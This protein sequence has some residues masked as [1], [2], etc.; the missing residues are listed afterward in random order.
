MIGNQW[1][2][3]LESWHLTILGKENKNFKVLAFSIYIFSNLTTFL[4]IL[5][6]HTLEKIQ[7]FY[8]ECACFLFERFEKF[9]TFYALAFKKSPL[10]STLLR[11]SH[12]VQ[13]KKKQF[14]LIIWKTIFLYFRERVKELHRRCVWITMLYFKKIYKLMRMLVCARSCINKC[15]LLKK[16]LQ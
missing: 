7:N 11:K 16:E 13:I 14:L 5:S 3:N 1:H 4:K 6:V 10:P 12:I 8:I 9:I 2:V 15:I